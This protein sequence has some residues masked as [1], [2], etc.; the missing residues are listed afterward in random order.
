MKYKLS[1]L[2]V[3]VNK[4]IQGKIGMLTAPNE[5]M[6]EAVRMVVSSQLVKLPSMIRTKK[7][8]ASMYGDPLVYV[9]PEDLESDSIIDIRKKGVS[10]RRSL[11]AYM[12]TPEEF[13]SYEYGYLNQPIAVD[14]SDNFKKILFRDDSVEMGHVWD[15]LD[16]TDNWLTVG[17]AADLKIDTGEYMVEDASLN[18]SITAGG[19]FAGIKTKKDFDFDLTKYIQSSGELFV[20]A[21]ISDSTKVSDIKLLIGS[22]ET[23]YYEVTANKD[24]LGKSFVD[25]FNLISFPLAGL[26]NATGNPDV[27]KMSFIQLSFSINDNT[28][29]GDDYRFDNIVF[30]I[31]RPYECK[32]YTRNAWLDSVTLEE[33]ESGEKEGDYLNITSEEWEIIKEQAFILAAQETDIEQNVIKAAEAKLIALMTIFSRKKPS[34]VLLKQTV[35]HSYL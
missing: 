15:K 27:T 6:S 7:I 20:W 14:E 29:T 24:Y 32:Y 10:F 18:F 35:Y 5:T 11:S 21:F 30:N 9:A 4:R 12:T 33:K 16:R 23:D 17:N 19:T 3:S 13:Y 26:S 1:D 25:G 22:S 2:K 34:Q 8:I 31:G 28:Y